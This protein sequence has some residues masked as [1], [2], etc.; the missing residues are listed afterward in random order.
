M[1]T[2]D[3]SLCRILAT[4]LSTLTLLSVD[5]S[6]LFQFI[7]ITF[8]KQVDSTLLIYYLIQ[9]PQECIDDRVC[10]IR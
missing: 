8:A 4:A 3:E 1:L 5:Q 7:V 2:V 6:G 10:R 9:M